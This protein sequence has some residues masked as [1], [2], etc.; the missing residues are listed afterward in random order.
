MIR[1]Y[2][3]YKKTK[4]NVSVVKIQSMNI[5]FHVILMMS[6]HSSAKLEDNQWNKYLFIVKE[7]TTI[8]TIV[9]KRK[10]SDQQ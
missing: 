7:M 5:S 4:Q 8:I 9:I 6:Q 1:H 10:M 3:F 2:N